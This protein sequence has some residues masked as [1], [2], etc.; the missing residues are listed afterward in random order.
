MVDP[1]P[2]SADLAARIQT[3]GDQLNGM[4]GNIETLQDRDNAISNR[5]TA[6][7]GLNAR[8]VRLE[9]LEARILALEN[10]NAR[11]GT[12]EGVMA[13]VVAIEGLIQVR[14]MP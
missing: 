4:R 1:V 11:L 10:L 9:G 2:N 6:V 13:R 7:E 14:R 3:I 5:V 12:L 8:V